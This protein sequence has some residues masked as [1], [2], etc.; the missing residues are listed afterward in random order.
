MS[1]HSLDALDRAILTALLADGRQSQVEL[2]EHVPLSSTAIARRI[3]TLEERGVISG[4]QAQISRAALGLTM[5][6]IVQVSLKSQNEELLAAFEKAAAAAPSIISCHMMSGEDDYIIV[7]LARD[8]ADFERIHKEQLSRLPGVARLRSS[9][10][11]R[12]VVSRPLPLSSL[13]R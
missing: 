3:R 10:V 1:P 13:E 9:F 12:E 7:V 11:L 8:L 6:A 2:A 4:Y 5:M